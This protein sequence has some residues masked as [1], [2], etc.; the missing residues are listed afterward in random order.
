ME[1]ARLSF[2]GGNSSCRQHIRQHY[3]IYKKKCQEAKIP[4]NHWAIPRDI[5]QKEKELETPAKDRQKQLDFQVVT[6]PREFTR[7]GTL[8]A[9]TTLIASNNQVSFDTV[10]HDHKPMHL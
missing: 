1:N 8:Q 4:M 3:E 7:S 5:W 2:K 9:V 10:Y 6:G